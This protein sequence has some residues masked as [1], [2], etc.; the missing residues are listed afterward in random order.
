MTHAWDSF[1]GEHVKSMTTSLCKKAGPPD[2]HSPAPHPIIDGESARLLVSVD[3][4]EC[5]DEI[6]AAV[7][8]HIADEH[9]SR[10]VGPD[11]ALSDLGF[12]SLRMVALMVD[13]EENLSVSFPSEMINAQTFRTVRSVADAVAKLLSTP[14]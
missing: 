2:K 4:D 1:S 11:T 8:R 9:E 5:I 12:G 14:S 10:L 3:M 13:V 7:R 6:T